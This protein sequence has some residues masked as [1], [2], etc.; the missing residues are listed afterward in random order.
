MLLPVTQ[1]D[2]AYYDLALKIA[3]ESSNSAK[4]G[5]IIVKG[6]RVISIACNRCVTHP[7]SQKYKRTT[8]HAEQRAIA[9]AK[10]FDG[11]LKGARLYSAKANGAKNSKPCI[12]CS[13]LIRDAEISTII[14]S[15]DNTICKERI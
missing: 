14:Y 2:I 8:I 1:A 12:M 7:I 6:A 10:N 15:Q 9:K 13:V 4:H 3:S 5:A 11:G